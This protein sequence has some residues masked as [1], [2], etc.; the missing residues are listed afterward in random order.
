MI[1]FLIPV[2]NETDNIALLADSITNCL[3]GESKFF[4]FVDDCSTD[5]TIAVINKHFADKSLQI[6]TKEA[7]G[8]PGDSFNKGFDW[9]LN[10]S[11]SADDI[12]VTLEGDNTS[13]IAILPTM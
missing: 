2:F 12:V 8:G 1:Y 5:N 13:D 7:N 9:I 10:H 11:A 6:I 3:P 4:V